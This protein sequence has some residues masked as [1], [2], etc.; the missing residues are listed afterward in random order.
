MKCCICQKIYNQKK[1]HEGK[2]DGTHGM[3]S[4]CQKRYDD[5]NDTQVA[6]ENQ[7][8]DLKEML[9]GDRSRTRRLRTQEKLIDLENQ[10]NKIN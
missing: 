10:L 6:L 4:K 2:V 7:I 8:K 9:E 3:C 5:L 1:D